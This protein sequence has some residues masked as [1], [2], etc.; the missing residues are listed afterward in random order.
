[1]LNLIV[2]EFHL[3]NSGLA[4]ESDSE[5]EIGSKG[6]MSIDMHSS[7]LAS[8]NQNLEPE[9]M[10]TNN[11]SHLYSVKHQ[12]DDS[13]SMSFVS[14]RL[15]EITAP[16]SSQLFHV[17]NT[18]DTGYQS[19]VVSTYCIED[20]S[21]MQYD[22][23]TKPRLQSGNQSPNKSAQNDWE[24]PSSSTPNKNHRI[25]TDNTHTSVWHQI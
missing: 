4:T 7:N 25:I 11:L 21:S 14:D 16:Q 17:Q 2:D 24:P 6:G 10:I 8:D 9:A 18:S 19:Q 5:D 1:M 13:V 23:H 15:G 20:T 22:H 12:Q 3:S